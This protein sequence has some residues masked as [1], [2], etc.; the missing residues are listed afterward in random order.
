MVEPNP[1]NITLNF[2]IQLEIRFLNHDNEDIILIQV[3]IFHIE[4]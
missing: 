1:S 3:C 4:I 2:E